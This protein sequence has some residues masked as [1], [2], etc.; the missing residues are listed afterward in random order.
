MYAVVDIK[1]FQY[2]LEK[3][4]SIRVP[5]YDVEVG[6]KIKINDVLL[7]SDG[8]K[9]SVGT[10]FVEGAIVEAT[11]A[12][13]DKNKKIIV[14]KKKRRKDYSVKKGHRQDFTEIVIDKIKIPRAK[15]TAKTQISKKKVKPEVK[16]TEVIPKTTEAS[17]IREVLE[18]NETAGNKIEKTKVAEQETSK[19]E[20]ED[21]KT[22]E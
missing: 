5:K 18:N 16:E 22:E 12:A 15:K 8:G 1:G 11:I 14:F 9:I 13:H 19:P 17:E 2:K 7:V 21:S 20:A 10:P 3:G 6:K 4:E